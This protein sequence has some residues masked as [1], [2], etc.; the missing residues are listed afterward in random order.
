MSKML[1]KA[2]KLTDDVESIK[3]A[4]EK[5]GKLYIRSGTD[6][7]EKG[8]PA[9]GDL[10]SLGKWGFRKVESGPELRDSDEIIDSLDKFSMNSSGI[11][12]FHG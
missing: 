12:K 8:Q 6:G 4:Y 1:V 9:Q 2:I 5:N 11:V 7:F 3:I 10:S